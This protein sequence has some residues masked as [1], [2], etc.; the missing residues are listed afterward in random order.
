VTKMTRRH[1]AFSLLAATAGLFPIPSL[2]QTDAEAFAKK[3]LEAVPPHGEMTLGDPKAPVT[4]IEYASLTC[5]HCAEFHN[6]IWPEIKRAYVDTGKVLFIL[7]EFPTNELAVGAFM[8][9][10][11][12]PYDKYFATID[13]MFETQAVWLKTD[14]KANLFKIVGAAGLDAAGAEICIKKEDLARAIFDTR[15]RAM[16]EF[17]VKGTPSFFVNGVYVNAHDD[18]AAVRKNLDQELMRLGNQ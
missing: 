2:A 9:A 12:V 11:C 15:K 4:M 3:L 10:R 6:N 5:P 17:N 16:E 18:A 13:A 7:R 1:A 8:L 14:T